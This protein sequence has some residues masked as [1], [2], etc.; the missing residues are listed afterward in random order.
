[1]A[2]SEAFG[3]TGGKVKTG[4]I[5]VEGAEQQGKSTFCQRLSQTLGI[6]VIHMHKGYGFVD[7][8]FDYTSG[9]FYDIDRRPG[10]FIYDRSYISELVYGRLFNRNNITR[11][12]QDRVET[13][14]NELGY[15]AVLL[16][17]N[18]PWIEREETVTREQNE[19]VKVLY[20]D[21]YE[22]LK[23]DKFFIK[24]DDVGLEYIIEQFRSRR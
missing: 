15:F 23:I 7:G 12:I 21:V 13:R 4:G 18:N 14:F 9:Y 19:Q 11:E 5:I 16:E 3:L 10:P 24:P 1:M 8:K 6:E 17:L 22:G 2:W 20:R